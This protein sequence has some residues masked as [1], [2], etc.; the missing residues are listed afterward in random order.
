MARPTTI[1]RVLAAALERAEHGGPGALSMEGIAAQAGVGKQ[2]LYRSWPSVHAILFDAL[3]AESAR[4]GA[5]ERHVSTVEL[6]QATTAELTAEP[7][8]SLLR[9]LTAAVQTDEEV[10]R[11]FRTRLLKPQREQIVQHLAADGHAEPERAADLL[12]APV[13]SRWLL[14]LP[15]LS[16]DEVRDHVERV[17][18]LEALPQSVAAARAGGISGPTDAQAIRSGGPHDGQESRR[19]GGPGS[20]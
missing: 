6:L 9:A 7:R 18:R 20:G 4:A 16:E 15:R 13:L 5:T 3:S 12:L 8:A 2:T 14:R 17:R 1:T 11:E 19:R 10:A